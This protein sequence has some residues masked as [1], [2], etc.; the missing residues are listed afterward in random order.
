MS[1]EEYLDMIRPYLRDM[2][3]NHKAPM[4]LRVH[5]GNEVTDYETHFGEWKIQLTMQIIF[6][7]SIDSRETCIM[8]VKSDNIEIMMVSKTKDIIKELKEPLLQNYQEGSEESMGE[9]RFIF[10]RADLLY[11]SREKTSLKRSGSYIKSPK[12]LKN[13]KATINP[14]NYDDD[15]CFKYAVTAALNY[16][17]IESH[18]ERISNIMPFIN[19]NDWKGIEFSIT[20][21]GLENI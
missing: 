1:P 7:S 2:I 4:E 16:Q 19:P 8:R 5:S 18:P 10:D 14:Q 15:N 3:N 13:K 6:I 12:W 20:L 21:K 17:I 11:Y 9:S